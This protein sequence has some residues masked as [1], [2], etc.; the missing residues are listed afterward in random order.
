MQFL[1]GA[2]YAIIHLLVSYTIPVAIRYEVIDKILSTSTVTSIATSVASDTA[3]PTATGAGAGIAFLKKLVYRAAGE[4]G[5]A[6][7]IYQPGHGG[8]SSH[9]AQEYAERVQHILHHHDVKR[10]I[11]RTEYQHIPCIDTSGQAFAIYLNVI[12]LAPLTGL[13]VRFFIKSYIRR[14]SPSTKRSTKRNA[15]SKAG[16]DA[17][18]GVDREVESLGRSAEDGVST[19]VQNPKHSVR[20]RTAKSSDHRNGSLSPANQKFFESFNKKVSQRLEDIGEGPKDTEKRARL[21][22]KEVVSSASTPKSERALS[23]NGSAIMVKKEEADGANGI[24]EQHAVN[25]AA[26]GAIRKT[27]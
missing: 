23:P 16:R 21:I 15:L 18:H 19:S 3:I 6:G 24:V 4:E 25:G 8:H 20:G 1:V 27:A 7:N 5:L 2:S 9:F 11:Y 12:Y 22:A 14:T 13:F 26:N 17:M 10:V